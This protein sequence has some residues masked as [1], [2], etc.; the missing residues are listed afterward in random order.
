MATSYQLPSDFEVLEG[1]V[2]ASNGHPKKG[3]PRFVDR[4]LHASKRRLRFSVESDFE[5]FDNFE[6]HL[7]SLPSVLHV[8]S[9]KWACCYVIVFKEDS[10]TDPLQW[11]LSLPQLTSDIPFVP[12]AIKSSSSSS[13]IEGIGEDDDEKFV[14]TRIILPSAP[15]V[16]H[17]GRTSFA[18][19]FG[20]RYFHHRLGAS[21]FR[22]AWSGLKMKKNQRRFS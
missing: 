10:A 7:H 15:W 16:G 8:R 19:S 2:S 17:S 1:G 20:D 12:E 22:R 13:T 5:D 11:L 3:L 21:R 4:V 6:R 14:P 9:N 18:T